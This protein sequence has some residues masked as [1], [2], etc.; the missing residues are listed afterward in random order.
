M[1]KAKSEFFF[2]SLPL[3]VLAIP[4][5]SLKSL[6]YI[7]VIQAGAVLL[8]SYAWHYFLFNRKGSRQEDGFYIEMEYSDRLKFDAFIFSLPFIVIIVPLIF[9]ESFNNINFAQAIAVFTISTFW[10]RFIFNKEEI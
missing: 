3:I 4:L 7:N 8:M 1:D 2:Y 5:I 6:S 10:Q 9:F